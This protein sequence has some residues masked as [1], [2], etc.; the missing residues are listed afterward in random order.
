MRRERLWR[1]RKQATSANSKLDRKTAQYREDGGNIAGNMPEKK[2]RIENAAEQT[3]REI[4]EIRGSF[5][6]LAAPRAGPVALSR[7]LYSP[8]V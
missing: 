5:P 7:P 4:R 8:I 2:P 6:L 3:I 1:R